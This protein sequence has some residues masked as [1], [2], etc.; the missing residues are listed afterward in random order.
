MSSGAFVA[1]PAHGYTDVANVSQ[2]FA[3]AGSKVTFLSN[4]PKLQV[5]VGSTIEIFLASR[6]SAMFAARRLKF[7]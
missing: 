3:S 1:E 5:V 2:T 6:S 4:V 7:K